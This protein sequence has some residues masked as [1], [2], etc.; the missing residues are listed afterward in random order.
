MLIPI[1]I[2]IGGILDQVKAQLQTV[3]LVG[4]GMGEI[5]INP[6]DQTRFF[7]VR[8]DVDGS[9]SLAGRVISE[10]EVDVWSALASALGVIIKWAA[11]PDTVVGDGHDVLLILGRGLNEFQ[12]AEVGEYYVGGDAVS[13]Q[14]GFCLP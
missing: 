9:S 10:V 13:D 12:S 8:F 4:D 1:V 3:E 7:A 6:V 14:C 2:I 5:L 11:S